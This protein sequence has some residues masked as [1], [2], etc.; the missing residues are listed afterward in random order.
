MLDNLATVTGLLDALFVPILLV[1]IFVLRRARE[2]GWGRVKE[3]LANGVTGLVL[4]PAAIVGAV[5]WIWVF[6]GV[7]SI[8]PWSIPT[9]WWSIVLAVVISDFIYYWE[10]R[11]SHEVRVLWDSFH[12]VHHSSPKFDQ[13]TGLRIGV[14]D[15]LATTGFHLP[16]I[17]MGFSTTLTLASIAAVLAY[18]TWIHTEVVRKMPRWFEAIFNTASHHRVHHGADDLYLDTNYGGILIVWDRMFGT[19]QAE[20]F[21]PTY[22]L[23]T[24]IESSNPI[25]IQLSQ[26]R[27]LWRDLRSDTS[28]RTRWARLWNRPGWN[29]APVAP[30]AEGVGR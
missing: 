17:V 9:T 7:G 22:G 14:V 2:L 15:G 1:E 24:Q 23:T 4:I 20:E 13:T 27:L 26:L 28:W 3:M 10:H 8:V 6:D 29:P 30:V 12:S 11:W 21:R 19:F 16:M 5:F 18:Q 25:D